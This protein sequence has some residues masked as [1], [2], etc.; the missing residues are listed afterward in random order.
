MTSVI[1]YMQSI[2]SID[3]QLMY[4]CVRRLENDQLSSFLMNHKGKEYTIIFKWYYDNNPCDFII[5][6]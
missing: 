2:M 5:Y 4:T 1:T 6:E 3:D